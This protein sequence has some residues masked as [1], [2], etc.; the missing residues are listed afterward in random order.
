MLVFLLQTIA[1]NLQRCQVD[2]IIA[3]F[4]CQDHNHIS[5]AKSKDLCGHEKCDPRLWM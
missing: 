5:F 1:I 4:C 3:L 2:A